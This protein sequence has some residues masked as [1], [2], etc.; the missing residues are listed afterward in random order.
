M[1]EILGLVAPF[2][3]IILLGFVSAKLT[4]IPL[5]GLAW[6]NF[7]V[8]YIALPPLFFRLLSTTPL[9]EFANTTFLVCATAATFFVFL[10]GFIIAKNRGTTRE[11]TVQAL[12]A[13]YGNIAI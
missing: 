1:I 12:A 7:F 3:L 9:S 13:A 10:I 6:L 8:V 2:F 5:E 11:A 4:H